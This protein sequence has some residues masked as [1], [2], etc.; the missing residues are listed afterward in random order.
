[1]TENEKKNPSSVVIQMTK[2]WQKELGQDE[3]VGQIQV[4][5]RLP[6]A[7]V[8]YP[9][10]F[11]QNIARGVIICEIFVIRLDFSRASSA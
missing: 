11:C 6:W 9:I 1:M 10:S 4:L 8:Y 5:V 2:V 7:D 3:H